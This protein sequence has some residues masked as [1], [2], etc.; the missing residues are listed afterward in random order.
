[1]RKEELDILLADY[2]SFCNSVGELD[3]DDGISSKFS[4]IYV[5]NFEKKRIIFTSEYVKNTFINKVLVAHKQ[6]LALL[7]QQVN[8]FCTVKGAIFEHFGHLTLK[9]E[10][11][12]DFKCIYSANSVSSITKNKF[13]MNLK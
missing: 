3:K 5:K 9:H 11:G 1:M 10:G 8:K 12:Y 13:K 4:H 2:K 6:D 7:L